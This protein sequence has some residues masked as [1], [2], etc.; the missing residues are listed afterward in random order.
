MAGSDLAKNA[1]ISRS[2]ARMGSSIRS[3]S[4]RMAVQSGVM[5]T[6]AC[7]RAVRPFKVGMVNGLRICRWPHR[8]LR[9]PDTKKAPDG[10]RGPW[11][12]RLYYGMS[13]CRLADRNLQRADA[14]DAALDGVARRQCGNPGRCPRHD[15]IARAERDLLGELPDDLGH[16]PDQLGQ[17]ALLPFYA[18]DRKPDAALGGVADLRRRLQHRARRGVVERFADLPRSLLLARG[19]LQVAARQVDA[20]GIAVDVVECLVGGN[21]EAAALHRHDQFDLVMQILG[22]RRIG[23]GGA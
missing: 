20:D 23:D 21:V 5:V 4:R 10:A 2:V 18:V 7:S 19:L 13:L 8:K 6:P 17:V 3:K 15:D 11:F 12:G 1:R 22:Q 16:A 9:K 14:I